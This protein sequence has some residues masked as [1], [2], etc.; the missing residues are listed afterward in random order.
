M[1]LI[2]SIPSGFHW[3][4]LVLPLHYLIEADADITAVLC[5][6]PG[7][8]EKDQIFQGYSPKF[9]FVP[10]PAGS[11]G[12]DAL[13]ADFAPDIVVTTTSGLDGRDTPL[14]LAA[15]KAGVKTFTF[16]ASWDNVWK[17][18]RFV[19]EGKQ[20]A[21]AER[22]AVWNEM[23]RSHV[24]RLFPDIADERILLPGVPRFD[25]FLDKAVIP[26][27]Q[28]LYDQL[29]LEDVS[30]PL[31]HL[32]TTE[33]YPM[34]YLAKTLRQAVDGGKI[35]G[36]P[37]L[38]ATVHPG[39]NRQRHQSLETYGVIVRYAFGR[40]DAI[41]TPEFRYAPTM[42][43]I[44]HHVALYTHS[45]VLINH[46]STTAI[47]SL[48]ADVPVINVRYGQA[49][50]WWRW[51]RSMVYRDFNEHYKDI[52]ANNGTTVVGSAS[53]L[54][55]ATVEAMQQPERKKEERLAT[56]RRMITHVDGQSSARMLAAIKET[57]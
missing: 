16:I 3:R 15:Q 26:S 39:G 55:A 2:F 23:M 36:N 43:D 13:I 12:Y 17:M 11:S 7:A 33:L 19:R 53:Q 47:E 37:Y 35:P 5:V 52:L 1:K 24:K 41:T 9:S 49:F 54:I 14:L 38:L 22:L 44:W 20:L 51:Y 21:I 34:D 6:T 40:K 56:V 42:Q 45:A 32:S 57:V 50:D 18:E 46:S 4:E 31:I 27:K 28:E 30:R 10:V 25:F 29:G 48:L 8:A